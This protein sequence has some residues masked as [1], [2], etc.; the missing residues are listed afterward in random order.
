MSF[1]KSIPC[2]TIL[3][4]SIMF[5]LSPSSAVNLPVASGGGGRSNEE[6][7]FLFKTW[8]SR[9]GKSYINSLSEKEQ[10]FE[11]FKDN[12]RFIDHHNAKNLSYKL[13]LNRFA[14]LT[15]QEYRDSFS[16]HAKPEHKANKTSQRYV[17]LDGD[18]V[19]ETV[20]WRQQ[21][22]VSEIKDQGNCSNCWAFSSVAAIEGINKIV[23]GELISLSEQE[24]VDCNTDNN[25]CG[26]GGYMDK[27]FEFLINNNGLDSQI[28]YPYNAVQGVCNRKKDGSNKIV[29]IDSYED[30][31]A[32]DEL[33]LKIAVSHQ[34]VSVGVDKKAQEFMLYKS[35]IYNGPCG[36]NLDHALVIVGYGNEN[37][38]DYWIVRNSWGK[39]WGEAGYAKMARNIK[40]SPSGLCGIAMMAS[41]PIKKSN[42]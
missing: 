38:Q 15:V 37:G 42:I 5:L 14:D 34:P 12:L 39:Q 32:N 35:G 6:V 18:Q 21:G 9:H 24:L 31:P 22:A 29:T 23:T 11:I 30:V 33:S 26:A 36:T 16:A 17:P 2:M 25:G 1:V 3:F 13:G 20:D 19:P 8:M 40:T 27:A 28:D 10:R 41:Y 4:L 7:N